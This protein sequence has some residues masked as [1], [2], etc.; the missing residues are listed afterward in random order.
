MTLA[1]RHRR[2]NDEFFFLGEVW[3]VRFYSREKKKKR[4]ILR[5]CKDKNYLSQGKD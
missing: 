1:R 5:T 2:R 4:K 3:K